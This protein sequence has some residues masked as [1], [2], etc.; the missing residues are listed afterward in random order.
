MTNYEIKVL[1]KVGE[2]FVNT[3]ADAERFS[4][5][6]NAYR[7]SNIRIECDYSL[8]VPVNTRL[9]RLANYAGD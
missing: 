6:V 3:Y 5:A 2:P 8:C 4:I 1:P 7:M 9:S